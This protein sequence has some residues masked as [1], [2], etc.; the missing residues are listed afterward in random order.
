PG[1]APAPAATAVPVN[2]TEIISIDG[3][4]VDVTHPKFDLG[5]LL[6]LFDGKRETMARTEN[7]T[8]AVIDLAFQGTKKAAGVDVITGT[9]DVGLKVTLTLVGKAEPLVLSKTMVQQT[10]EPVV[11]LDFG[12]V[13]EFKRAKVEVTNL[14]RGDGHIHIYEVKFK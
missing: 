9:M 8:T 14:N 10:T 1:T 7:A 5:Q 12:G 11:S 3:V 2:L 6:D 4:L 13:Q